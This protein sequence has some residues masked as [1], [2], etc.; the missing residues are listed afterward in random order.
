FG[1]PLFVAA[2]AACGS[3]SPAVT[4]PAPVVKSEGAAV[5][6]PAAPAEPGG[7]A[8]AQPTLRLPRNFLPTGYAA[9]LDLDPSKAGFEGSIQIAGNVSEP[10]RVI[11]LNA[12]KLTVHKAVAQRTG[13]PDVALTATPRGEDFLEL[14]A[15]RALDAGAWTLAIDYAG[16][17]D[18]LNTAGAFKQTVGDASYVYSQFEAVYARRAFPCFDEPDNKV[19]WKLTLDV[20]KQL[21]AVNNAPQL[22]ESPLDGGKK[23]VEFGVTKPL[24]SYLVAFGVGPFEVVDAGKTKRGTPVRIVTL[25]HRAADAAYAAKTSARVIDLLEEYFGAPYP[26]EKMDMLTIP[27]T[28]GFGAME[29]AGLITYTETSVLFDA[30][31][32]KER[33]LRWIAVAAHELAHQWFGDL[34]T[35]AY[36]D[37][38]WLNEGFA[39]WMGRKIVAR[40]EPAW[41]EDQGEL[42]T[43]DSALDND[44]L[45]T[46]RQ[47]R[48]PI[49]KQ[50]D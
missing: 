38:I 1:L 2:G 19:P 17:F 30:K 41:R 7:L 35:M 44:S 40:F 50:D 32:S 23:R 5:D 10:S 21:V 34:V 20:P 47:I 15:P 22:S 48:Q 42:N 14:R 25:A 24:P 45:V 8:P 29:N 27:I 39:S 16:E 6:K 49:V 18:A 13:Q 12:R 37:D 46:A 43:R 28:V 26:Y 31:A 36:W 9:R 33:H 3:S 11:W 4:V